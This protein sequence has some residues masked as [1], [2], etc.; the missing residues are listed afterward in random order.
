VIVRGVLLAAFVLLHPLAQALAQDVSVTIFEHGI[1]TAEIVRTEKLP[2][3]FNSNIVDKLC[4]VMTTGSVPA[5]MGLQFGFRFRVEGAPAG[6]TVEL[7]RVTRFPSPVKPPGNPVAQPQSEQ[8]LRVR[9]GSNS[10]VGYGF[11]HDWELVH[12]PWLLEIWQGQRP[13]ARQRFDI[14]GDGE[15]PAERPRS[16]DNCFELSASLAPNLNAGGMR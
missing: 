4:H 13:L 15:R 6:A 5:R 16:N 1:Y 8:T 14:G 2:N 9:V 11:D 3:G 10:Y 12:G 7:R